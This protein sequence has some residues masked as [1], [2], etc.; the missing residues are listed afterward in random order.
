[1]GGMARVAQA[2]WVG[3][4]D[5]VRILLLYQSPYMESTKKILQVLWL[6]ME[7]TYQSKSYL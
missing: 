1:V 7:A 2:K 3:V 5:V 6:V 4:G